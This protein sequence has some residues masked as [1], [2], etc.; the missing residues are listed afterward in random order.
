MNCDVVMK[1]DIKA[2]LKFIQNNANI[3]YIWMVRDGRDG[4]FY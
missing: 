1:I 4:T 3:K 2:I